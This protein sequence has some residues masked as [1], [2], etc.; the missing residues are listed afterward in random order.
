MANAA[1]LVPAGRRRHDFCI[2]KRDCDR[3]APATS[4]GHAAVVRHE[5]PE[6]LYRSRS[7]DDEIPSSMKV[8]V[9]GG[10]GRA[11]A[12]AGKAA[13]FQASSACSLPGT[14]ERRTNRA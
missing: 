8:L 7:P 11:H 12:L 2:S 4:L 9:I 14:P 10:G 13:Q 5:G 3:N 6:W 1:A